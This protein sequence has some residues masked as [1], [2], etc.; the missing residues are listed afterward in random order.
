MPNL[1]WT[2]ERRHSWATDGDVSLMVSEA[3]SPGGFVVEAR[4][5]TPRDGLIA[6]TVERE[7]RDQAK[8]MIEAEWAAYKAQ[9]AAADATAR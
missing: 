7:T 8:D 6:G 1:H 9:H 2:D 3:S 5:R 4:R